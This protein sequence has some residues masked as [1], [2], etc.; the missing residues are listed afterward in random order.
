MRTTSLTAKTFRRCCEVGAGRLDARI[1]IAAAFALAALVASLI[2]AALVAPARAQSADEG[3]YGAAGGCQDSREIRRFT[4]DQDQTTEPFR[5]PGDAFRVRYTTEDAAGG[6]ETLRVNVLDEEGRPTGRSFVA[7]DG[8]GGSKVFGL[9]PGVFRLEIHDE[10]LR[11]EIAVEVCGGGGNGGGGSG[12]GG[13]G[14]GSGNGGTGGVVVANNEETT[15]ETIE[16]TTEET[17]EETNENAAGNNGN[18][19]GARAEDVDAAAE[20]NCV[21]ILRVF[22]ASGASGAQYQY[23]D[24]KL[25]R[26]REFDL[27]DDDRLQEC[28]AR[29]VIDKDAV[30]GKTLADTGGAPILP[31]AAMVLAGVGIFVG[32]SVLF[33]GGGGGSSRDD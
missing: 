8:E 26:N 4:G 19:E 27:F 21:E 17:I 7:S 6:G 20:L 12:G 29:E 28:L 32:R 23:K 25:E 16:E 1:S 30:A 10:G 31:V 15:E 14:G 11:Y 33:G 5:V 3:Q 18:L 24:L 13:N 2:V 9:G 22:R